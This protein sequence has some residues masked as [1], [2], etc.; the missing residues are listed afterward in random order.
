MNTFRVVSIASATVLLAFLL[1]PRLIPMSHEEQGTPSMSKSTLPIVG[2]S[3]L[4]WSTGTSIGKIVAE[5]PQAGRILELVGID[6]CCGG[7]TPL[8]EAAAEKN[9]DATQLLNA[10]RVVGNSPGEESERDWQQAEISELLEHIIMTHHTWLRRELPGLTTTSQTVLKVHG[11]THPELAEVVTTFDKIRNAVLPHL[12]DEEQRIF[13]ALLGL[14]AGNPPADMDKQLDEMRSDHDALGAELHRLRKLTRGF[15][16]PSDACTKY[17]EMLSGFS[18]LEQD[19]HRHVHL[20][21]NVLLPRAQTMLAA[22]N[23]P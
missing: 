15:E 7:L 16:P 22:V 14:V 19:L 5:Q 6:Y 13:P 2:A 3:S 17:R 1:V 20:E 8:G 18:A 11:E 23:K 10:L 12:D 21:N 4:T 9:L